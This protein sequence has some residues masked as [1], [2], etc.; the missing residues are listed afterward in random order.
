MTRLLNYAADVTF[1]LVCALSVTGAVAS[2][3]RLMT[4]WR[5][6]WVLW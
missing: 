2:T 4:Q 6:G 5:L 1:L 3:Y